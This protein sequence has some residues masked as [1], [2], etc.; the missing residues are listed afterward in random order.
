MDRCSEKKHWGTWKTLQQKAFEHFAV[1]LQM[2]LMMHM[3]YVRMIFCLDLCSVFWDIGQKQSRF[4]D[5]ASYQDCL[6]GV[7]K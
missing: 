1:Q 7:I 5:Y 6:K 4:R 2:Y 3:R